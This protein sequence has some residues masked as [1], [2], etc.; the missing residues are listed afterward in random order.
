MRTGIH[1]S[2]KI[3]KIGKLGY[4]CH[5]GQRRKGEGVESEILKEAGNLQVVEEEGNLLDR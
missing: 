5:F 3:P 4:I 1:I 2:M